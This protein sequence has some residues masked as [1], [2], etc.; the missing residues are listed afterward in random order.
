MALWAGVLLPFVTTAAEMQTNFVLV[1]QACAGERR[2]ALFAV[3]I[4][5]LVIIGLSGFISAVIYRKQGAV[6]PTEKHDTA[7]RSRF[8]AVLGM[9]T[10]ALSFALVLGHGIATLKFDPCQP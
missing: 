2:V 7:N 3:V 9:M 4:V 6:W 10:A 8:I 5:A 1:R